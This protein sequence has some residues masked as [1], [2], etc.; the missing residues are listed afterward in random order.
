[1]IF[2]G[3]ENSNLVA[4]G[5]WVAVGAVYV[6]AKTKALGHSVTIDF[7]R[8]VDLEEICCPAKSYGSATTQ[9][10]A[11]GCFPARSI[12]PQDSRTRSCGERLIVSELVRFPCTRSMSRRIAVPPSS[13]FG[14]SIVVSRGWKQPSHG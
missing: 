7:N 10:L 11:W 6:L 4:G 12:N 3:V 13:Y 9:R 1:V 8:V 5:I 2:L 14:N